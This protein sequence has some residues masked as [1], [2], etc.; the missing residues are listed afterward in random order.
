MPLTNEQRDRIRASVAAVRRTP[1]F[2]PIRQF[3]VAE[4]AKDEPEF[5]TLISWIQGAWRE[6]IEAEVEGAWI[7]RR[8]SAAKP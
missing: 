4:T 8:K 2:S 1:E 5:D 7:V 3:L 6:A